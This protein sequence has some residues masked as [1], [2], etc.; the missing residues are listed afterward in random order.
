M[1]T[2]PTT[3]TEIRNAAASMFADKAVI[4][5]NI[6]ASFGMVTVYRNGDIFAA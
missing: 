5:A 4:S 1:K 6:T 3:L 2:L